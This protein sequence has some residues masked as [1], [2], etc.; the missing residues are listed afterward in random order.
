ML[1]HLEAALEDKSIAYTIEPK[2]FPTIY[3][4][5]GVEL[6]S[7]SSRAESAEFAAARK[8]SAVIII[9][10]IGLLSLELFVITIFPPLSCQ[11]I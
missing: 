8:K 3:T 7:A 1:S 10:G 11:G 6:P 2:E 9:N 5:T 4:L